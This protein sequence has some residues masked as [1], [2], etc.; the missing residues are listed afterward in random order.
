[1]H[2]RRNHVKSLYR[3]GAK[4]FQVLIV[5]AFIF[6]LLGVRPAGEAFAEG[7]V[8]KIAVITD[9]GVA[10]SDS[11]KANIATLVTNWDP[12]AVVTGGDNYHDRA[13]SCGS[14]AECV[15]GYN[16]YT[17]GYTDFV[18]SETFFPAYG[19]HDAGHSAAYI[20]YFSYLPSD[21]DPNHLYYDVKIGNIHF[22]VLN[23]NV[24]LAG[25]AQETW[26]AANAP[27]ESVAWNI[28]IVH[29]PP[30]GT[31]FYGDS[32]GT[33]FFG[34]D[35]I[36][37][38]E[39]YGIDFVIGGHNHHYERLVKDGVRYFIAGRA[40]VTE[41]GRTCTGIGS[42]A[43]VEFCAGTQNPPLDNYG[44]MQIVATTTEISLSFVDESGVVKDTFTKI[45]E[46]PINTAITSVAVSDIDVPAALGKP[47][48]EATIAATPAAGI[49]S[50]TA[51]VTWDPDENPFDYITVYTASVTLTAATGHK[52]TSGTSATVNGQEADVVLNGDGTVTISYTFPMTEAEPVVYEIYLPLIMK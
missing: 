14:Y 32:D 7:G 23:G 27:D 5:L 43:T 21:P 25:S 13:P 28:V 2:S 50:T 11:H 42:A 47:D 44:Y 16:S 52:F 34:D 37:D 26:L 29:Q 1:M 51:A 20:S 30:Y 17:A 49:T 40:G 41:G 24:T 45:I 10:I 39:N 35:T 46:G 18:S 19:N 4:F 15:A 6:S 22:W 9:F 33:G 38:Y 36:L 8:T 31:G 12:D 48:T 3:T